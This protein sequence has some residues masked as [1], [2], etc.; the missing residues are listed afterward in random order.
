MSLLTK[1]NETNLRSLRYGKDK[2]FGGSSNQPYITKP[3]PDNDSS[4][5]NTGGPD[6]LLRG[7]TLAVTKTAD[8]VSRLTKMFFDTKTANG[9]LF[10]AK[11]NLLTRLGVKTQ[12]GGQEIYLPTSTLAQAGV[13]AFGL[14]F[15]KQGLNPI[16][17]P[18]NGAIIPLGPLGAIS[19][20]GNI[21]SYSQVVNNN[22]TPN[23]NRLIQLTSNKILG[24]NV[25]S[26]NITSNTDNI[27]IFKYG[28]GPGS[29]LGI[30]PTLIKFGSDRITRGIGD[31]FYNYTNSTFSTLPY[32]LINNIAK[33][34]ET[35]GLT[36]PFSPKIVDFRKNLQTQISSIMSKSPD[37]SGNA[38]IEQR[39]YLGNPGERGDI[40]SY[41]AGKK[42]FTGRVLGALDKI[43]AKQLYQS[44]LVNSYGTNDLVKFRIEAIDND[45][46]GQS[47]FIHFRA[48]LDSFSDA[49]NA[50]W[51]PTR[52]VGRGE[53]FY[54]YGGFTRGITMGW[55]TAAQSKQELIPMYQ[56]LNYLAS[57]LT[58]DYSDNGYMRGPM[59]RLT[60]GGYLYSQPGFITNL[61]Y[62]ID[63][64]SPWEIG[65]ND[66]DAKSDN[67]V[68]ELPH[69]I[70]V[71][72]NYTPIHTFVPR[73]Q[74]NEYRGLT[75][76]AG[77]INNE[78][79]NANQVS[80]FGPERYIALNTGNHNN[81]SDDPNYI[82]LN[83]IQNITPK[84]PINLS[85]VTPTLRTPQPIRPIYGALNRG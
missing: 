30:G 36:T 41:T 61:T 16:P 64:S 78:T 28:G 29:I 10:I 60:V 66:T 22:Q 74:T 5:G 18:S 39:T 13:E 51:N 2:V 3:I 4:I 72:M 77:T 19:P 52:Y 23:D 26:N 40:S 47:V 80:E 17:I 79:V 32:Y 56:K 81:Y 82:E 53:E 75:T 6:F 31:E 44:R 20:T 58:P 42:D 33:T 67:S 85:P 21:I 27:N 68:K 76:I 1:L 25:T 73:K 65:I 48:F 24:L 57:N 38:A 12:A 37:Y 43:N 70:R 46:P 55:T 14:H 34:N 83:E 9:A 49:Y 63:E 69:V 35:K 7:G 54:T 45:D 11:Q 50:T 8:D 62:T 15:Y 71:S 84:Q 59:M